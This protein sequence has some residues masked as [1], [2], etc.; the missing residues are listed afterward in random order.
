MSKHKLGSEDL[1]AL[2]DELGGAVAAFAQRRPAPPRENPPP[3]EPPLAD[4]ANVRANGRTFER[5]TLE[6]RRTR[7]SFDIYSDQ[8]TSL[9]EIALDREKVSGKRVLLGDLVQEALDGFIAAER[10]KD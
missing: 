10:T 5:Q 4:S 7:H 6:R 8:L 2:A 3:A 9:R 1:S